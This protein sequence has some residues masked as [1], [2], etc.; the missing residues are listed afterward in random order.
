LEEKY[1]RLVK[2]YRKWYA[3]NAYAPDD[4]RKK[5]SALMNRLRTE[6]K[7]NGRWPDSEPQP[8]YSALVPES[9]ATPQLALAFAP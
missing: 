2:Q 5:I 4:Y 8:D 9:G 7:L 1:P 6:H 3:R